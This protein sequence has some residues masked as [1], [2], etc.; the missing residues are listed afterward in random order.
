MYDY[1]PGNGR[2]ARPW[3]VVRDLGDALGKTGRFSPMRNDIEAFSA[4]QFITK[5]H[6]EFVE[7]DYRGLHQ[8]LV[9]ERITPGDVAWAS[10]LLGGLD[11]RQWQDAFRA[12]GYPPALATRFIA[13]LRAR[14]DEARRIGAVTS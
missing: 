1:D 7:F 12:G 5:A 3:Y 4:T 11:E 9:R 8:E 14:V 6:G 13:I 10:H 2:P